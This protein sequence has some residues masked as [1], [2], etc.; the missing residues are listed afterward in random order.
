MTKDPV[1]LDTRWNLT[2]QIKALNSCRQ[3]LVAQTHNV[4]SQLYARGF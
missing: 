3:E 1:E 4:F 2:V